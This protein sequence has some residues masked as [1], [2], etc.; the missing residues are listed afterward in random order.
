MEKTD[1]KIILNPKNDE[2][3]QQKKKMKKLFRKD[4]VNIVF[5]QN[6]YNFN[7]IDESP[8]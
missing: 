1:R 6:T 3:S 7:F 8:Q 4:N 2:K 5:N